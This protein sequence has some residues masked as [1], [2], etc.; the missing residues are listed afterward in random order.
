LRIEIAR[1][2]SLAIGFDLDGGCGESLEGPAE[3]T[4]P[5]PCADTAQPHR[6][7]IEIAR[8]ISPRKAFDSGWICGGRWVLARVGWRGSVARMLP[9]D[10]L[11]EE[12]ARKESRAV[13]LTD[14]RGRAVGTFLFREHYCNDVGCDCGIVL[15]HAVWAERR[16]VAGSF[17]YSFEPF[18]DEPQ[19]E[20]D[21]LNPQSDLSGTLLSWFERALAEDAAYRPALLR[22]YAMWRR[23]VDDPSHPDHRKLGGRVHGKPST[24]QGGRGGA[25]KGWQNAPAPPRAPKRTQQQ[26]R[27]ELP[28][29]V[30]ATAESVASKGS[31]TGLELLT[32]GRVAEGK[33]QQRFRKLLEKVDRLKLRLVTWRERR[34]AIESEIASCQ[35]AQRRQDD[36]RQ[37][38]VF[39]LD[40]AHSKLSKADRRY[41]SGLIQELAGELLRDG[42]AED[43]HAEL[44]RLYERHA[45]R[46]FAEEQA[47]DASMMKSMLDS[48]GIDLGDE[49]DLGTPEQVMA[50]AREKLEARQKEP[51]RSR[52][53]RQTK[54][55]RSAKQLAAEERRAGEAR[56]AHKAV[57]DVYRQLVRAAH[58]DRE[59]DPAERDRKTGLM[60]EINAAYE[61]RD[62]LAL[63]ELQLRLER[64]AAAEAPESLAEERIASYIRVLDEQAKQ[65]TVELDEIELPFRLTLGRGPREVVT[66][67]MVIDQI[68]ADLRG[69]EMAAAEL[70]DDLAAFEDLARLK[71]WLKSQRA[72]AR[73]SPVRPDDDDMSFDIPF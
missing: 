15:I 14:P 12:V 40:R 22:H 42:A 17:S 55:K 20:L 18:R 57:Q 2:I 70:T 27:C 71:E 54:R 43:E 35:H 6:L 62:L 30:P 41:V 61:A 64:V 4:T 5:F 11:F 29:G 21:P 7:R 44:T 37:R 25:K 36:L 66:P 33:L 51:L 49:V 58:P 53:E 38:M 24:R 60:R 26:A 46:A 16:Q 28:P 34:A 48:L 72:A 65:L 56:D 13:T 23:V 47:E 19:L 52:D 3:T 68:R 69:I 39:L 9:F 59:S 50:K 31:A 8:R 10:L 32:R 63:L 73:R 67:A 1:R 45:G